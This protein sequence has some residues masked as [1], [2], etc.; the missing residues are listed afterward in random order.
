MGFV[1][2]KLV[3]IAPY[4]PYN[5]VAHAGGKTFNFYLNAF[6]ESKKFEIKG[7]FF[8]RHEELKNYDLYNKISADLYCYYNT[9]FKQILRWLINL[10]YALN[11]FHKYAGFAR[12]YDRIKILK[13]L[14]RYKKEQ[15]IPEY[16]ILQWTQVILFSKDIKKIFPDAKIIAIEEDVTF[17][18]FERR[19]GLTK[20]KISKWL[21]KIKS[22]NITK[23]EISAINVSDLVI[24]N[25]NKDKELLISHNINSR[26]IKV[27][28]TFFDDYTNVNYNAK[29]KNILF[30][31]AMNRK[32]NDLSAKWLLDNVKPLLKNDEIK[33]LIIGGAPS[34]SL[35]RYASENVIITGY[36]NDVSAYLNDV[37]CLAAPL[38]LGA[39]IKVKVLEAFCAGIPVLTNDIGIEGIPALDGKEYFHCSCA[40]EYADKINFLLDNEKFAEN[41]SAN[42]KNFIL[43][44]FNYK[45]DAQMIIKC[46]TE[47]EI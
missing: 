9:G 34:E 16:I 17:L 4:L 27:W 5:N 36:V 37:L 12:N 26:K 30:Y 35:K 43:N 42:A 24:V 38:V 47:N 7:I 32:E 22:K 31:G 40:L 10:N 45:H 46:L 20:L 18:S 15:F 6:I 8:Y 28:T 21:A 3:W 25:N 44:N 41:M 14:R 29:S 1:M 39:G 33:F 19:I 23:Y 2:K 13:T 11:P